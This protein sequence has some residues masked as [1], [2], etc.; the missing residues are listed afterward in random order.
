MV[1]VPAMLRRWHSAR[2]LGLEVESLEMDGVAVSER[3]LH[4][5]NLWIGAG[6]AFN[7]ARQDYFEAWARLE[8]VLKSPFQL[9]RR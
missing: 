6:G 8:R 1:S 5:L 7:A 2:L 4:L 9:P 3:T